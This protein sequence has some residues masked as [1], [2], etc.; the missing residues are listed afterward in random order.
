[1]ATFDP[2]MSLGTS[3]LGGDLGVRR[4]RPHAAGGG[5]GRSAARPGI[6]QRGPGA[7]RARRRPSLGR[8]GLRTDGDRRHADE[9]LRHEPAASGRPRPV[10]EHLD[11]LD[12]R[13][14]LQL[15]WRALARALRTSGVQRNAAV[16]EAL[17]WRQA[18]RHIYPAAEQNERALEM[19]EGTASYAG[20]VLAASSRADA[21]ASALDIPTGSEN[22]ESFVRTLAYASGIGSTRRRDP[23]R[24]AGSEANGMTWV[25]SPFPGGP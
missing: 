22:G 19:N 8:V 5:T 24:R 9:D 20:T 3:V 16:R 6:F 13:Y 17:A 10:N 15:E 7:V 12:G 4:R 14:W 2:L 21:T 25:T 18:R 11:A 23:G 1:M